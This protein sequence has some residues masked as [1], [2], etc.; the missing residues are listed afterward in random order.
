MSVPHFDTFLAKRCRIKGGCAYIQYGA[1]NLCNGV[2]FS[3]KLLLYDFDVSKVTSNSLWYD[4]RL[5]SFDFAV[6]DQIQCVEVC[7]H[8]QK[9][10]RAKIYLCLYLRKQFFLWSM[11]KK[12]K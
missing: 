1:Q 7:I 9:G 2:S 10:G 4:F 6:W 5:S 8:G 11:L 12:K 3:P